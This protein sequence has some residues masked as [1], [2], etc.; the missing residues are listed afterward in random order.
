MKREIGREIYSIFPAT[1]V[2][3]LHFPT[4][5]EDWVHDMSSKQLYT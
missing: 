2:V 5:L 1:D 3:V 4:E